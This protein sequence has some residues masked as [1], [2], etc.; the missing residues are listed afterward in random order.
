MDTRATKDMDTRVMVMDMMITRDMD[1]RATKDMDMM[2]TRDMGTRVMV[3]DMMITR[4]MVTRVMGMDMITTVDTT[5][6]I[7][8]II[9][10]DVCLLI[11]YNYRYLLVIRYLILHTYFFLLV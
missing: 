8:D 4:D 1:T 6:I 9:S 10:L 7:L 5:M 2:T 11:N 3:M